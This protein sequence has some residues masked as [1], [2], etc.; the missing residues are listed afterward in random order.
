MTV[1]ERFADYARSI[2]ER[3]REDGVRAELGSGH[4]TLGKAIRQAATEKIPNVLVIGEREVEEETITLRRH[5]Q[6]E[7]ETMPAEEFRARVREA[8]RTRAKSF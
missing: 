2:V 1:S 5:G 4:E 8:I 3:L 7:Q 6:R